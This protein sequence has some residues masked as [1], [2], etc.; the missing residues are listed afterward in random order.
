M[1]ATE[2][3]NSSENDVKR[4]SKSSYDF[5]HF[6]KSTVTSTASS[7]F[8][9]KSGENEFDVVDK[10]Y[11]RLSL[12]DIDIK[13]PRDSESLTSKRFSKRMLTSDIKMKE[14]IHTYTDA[15]ELL[16]NTGDDHEGL[17]QGIC[18]ASE[19]GR[20]LLNEIKKAEKPIKPPLNIQD[21]AFNYLDKHIF[22]ILLPAMEET[23]LAAKEWDCL[24][25]QKCRFNGLDY[26]AEILWNKNPRYPERAKVWTKI[27]DIPFAK[28]WLKEHPRPYYPL[29]WLLSKEDAAIIIQ[30]AIRGFLVRCKPEVQ[31][32]RQFWKALRGEK[33]E[34]Q[35][36]KQQHIEE[37]A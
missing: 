5:P 12:D 33:L 30:S 8:S 17:W 3:K 19:E 2:R 21:T 27:F 22:P 13:V 29:S 36:R 18:E 37:W 14:S 6:S 24:W 7:N 4:D 25:V 9:G 15:T 11:Q 34:E 23:L 35:R 28:E 16:Q 32:M 20:Q 31:E 10:V 26:L 1:K